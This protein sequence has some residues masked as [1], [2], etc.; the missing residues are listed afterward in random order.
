MADLPIDTDLFDILV[1][2]ESK[3]PLKWTGEALVSTDAATR[4]SYRIDNG[5]PIML[6]EESLQLDEAAWKAAMELE[7]PVGKG[8]TDL[9][10]KS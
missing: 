5:I 8:V 4:R 1:C 10:S 6:L 2:P 3:A 9:S 7:G